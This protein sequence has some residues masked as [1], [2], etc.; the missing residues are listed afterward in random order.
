MDLEKATD[1]DPFLLKY[2]E[3]MRTDLNN[4]FSTIKRKVSALN[5]FFS[6]LERYGHIKANPVPSF[7]E[8]HMSVYKEP[9]SEMRFVPDVKEVKTILLSLK[10]IRALFMHL[11]FAKTGVRPMEVRIAD[12]DDFYWDRKYWKLKDHPKRTGKIIPLDDEL[13]MIGK[14]YFETRNDDNPA[15]F[16]GPQSKRINK[17]ALRE[18]LE[19]PFKKLGFYK[20]SG[21]LN[22]RMTPY[23]YRH[24]ANTE[25]TLNDIPRGLL[26]EICGD[27][28][29]STDIRERYIHYNEREIV[30]QYQKYTIPLLRKSMRIPKK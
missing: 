12:R 23:S 22:E 11:L 25:L 19:I 7:R 24:F 29:E 5:K 3:Y 15:L 20:E 6:Y 18:E 27:K 4:G 16:L 8:W 28:R 13:I 21:A 14:A 17:D 9:D 10:T 1:Y 30:R 2:L 26:K